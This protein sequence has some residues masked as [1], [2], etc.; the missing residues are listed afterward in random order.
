MWFFIEFRFLAQENCVRHQKKS[1]ISHSMTPRWKWIRK[2]HKKK[3]QLK[4][5][6]ILKSNECD[7]C[8]RYLY[9][10]GRKGNERILIC[11]NFICVFHV[12]ARFF[13]V[14]FPF[15]SGLLFSTSRF[16]FVSSSLIRNLMCVWSHRACVSFMLRWF[17]LNSRLRQLR[18]RCQSLTGRHTGIMRLVELLL[19]LFELLGTKCCTITTEFRLITIETWRVFALDI[20]RSIFWIRTQNSY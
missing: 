13:L 1:I 11:P 12:W 20:W 9:A 2:L 7:V 4:R 18:T 19:Q 6:S 16:F 3:H 14:I 17:Y 5:V 8:A 10:M 15:S